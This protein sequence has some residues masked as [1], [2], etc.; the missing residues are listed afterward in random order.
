MKLL[1]S[2]AFVT[3]LLSA[4]SNAEPTA[5]NLNTDNCHYCKMTIADLHFAAELITEKGKVYKF[6]DA[7]CMLNYYKENKISSEARLY[8]CDYS[9]P[10]Q[11]IE[12]KAAF[13]AQGEEVASPMGGNM[14]A[15]SNQAAAQNFASSKHAAVVPGTDL[16]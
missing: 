14:A 9:S 11:F 3:L 7:S 10:Q 13:F 4:C 15:F 16:Q 2:L 1:S 5:I 12:S 6:D 8:V